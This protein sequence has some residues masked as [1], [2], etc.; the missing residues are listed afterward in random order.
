MSIVESTHWYVYKGGWSQGPFTVD[1]VRH[2]YAAAWISRVDRVGNSKQGPWQPLH[3]MLDLTQVAP[4]AIAPPPDAIWE[5]SA[6][7][8][9]GSQPVSYGMLQMIAA[10]GNLKPT[11]SIRHVGET[12]WRKAGDFPGI[13][14]GPR[15]WCTA[16]GAEADPDDRRCPVCHASQ[17]DFEP[18]MATFALVCGVAASVWGI[19]ATA[20]VTSAA[21]RRTTILDVAVD[22]YFPHVF[23][24]FLGPS[25]LLAVL[26]VTLARLTRHD[27]RSGRS[28]PVQ[29]LRA[30]KAETLGW[31]TL[32]ALAMIAVAVA[33]YTVAHFRVRL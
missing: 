8:F 10:A 13:F 6:P 16:C 21:L 1:Q 23:A 7:R 19:V 20:A 15:A 4:D 17:P 22:E 26:G 24:V 25:G 32:L 18:S 33:A 28:A 11:D 31:V 30:E 2:M 5:I 3:V 29:L 9:Q 14:G 12:R 27:I